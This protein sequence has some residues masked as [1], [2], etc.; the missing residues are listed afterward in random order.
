MCYHYLHNVMDVYL[1]FV[2]VI[3]ISCFTWFTFQLKL[4]SASLRR[5]MQ[6]KDAW[7]QDAE[8]NIWT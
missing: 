2:M 1:Y 6:I 5:R 7:E 8:E 4:S 3:Q